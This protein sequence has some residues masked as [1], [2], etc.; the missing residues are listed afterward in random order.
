MHKLPIVSLAALALAAVSARALACENCKSDVVFGKPV[1]VGMGMAWS[2]AR[3]DKTTK[4]PVAVGVTLTETALQG[5]PTE[6][7]AGETMRWL[8][9]RL[10]LPKEVQGQPFDHVSL[11][12]NPKGHIPPGVYDVPHFD[13][14]F[15][16]ISVA[17]REKI[18]TS[19]EDQ[20]R[21]AKQPAPDYV[22]PGYVLPPG[23]FEPTMGSHWVSMTFPELNG[24]PFTSTF[25]YGS[26][27]GRTTFF[28]PMV[29]TAFLQTKPDFRQELKMPAAYQRAG[30]YPTS[31][32]VYYNPERKEYSISLEGLTHHKATKAKAAK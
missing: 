23:T 30:Y 9:Y 22:M 10:E 19:A 29:T 2:W 7:P 20:K 27:D 8:E 24:K 3:L 12:Y 6:M 4:K 32:R 17:D 5:L 1:V 21:G 31:Y 11:D 28:E 18:T 15:Y 26:F 13:V 25:I 14:H 16:T